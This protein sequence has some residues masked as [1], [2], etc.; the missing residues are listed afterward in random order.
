MSEPPHARL[1]A[2]YRTLIGLRRE[3]ADLGDPR[4]DLVEVAHDLDAQT[5]VVRRGAH[6]VVVN[7]AP[8]E[9]TVGFASEI[10]L[11]VVAAWDLDTTHVAPG[12]VTVPGHAAVI[13]GPTG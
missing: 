2:W 9:R 7:L 11:E 8:D 1:L 4:L 12:K 13:L 10:E 5:V 6:V 3:R